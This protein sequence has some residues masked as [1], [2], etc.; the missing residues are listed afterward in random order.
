MKNKSFKILSIPLLF[1]AFGIIL[2]FNSVD[3]YCELK[4]DTLTIHNEFSGKLSQE[5]K[6]SDDDYKNI[7]VKGPMSKADF[8]DLSLIS[9]KCES[10]NIFDVDATTI[11]AGLFRGNLKLKSFTFPKKLK[12][13]GAFS[14]SDCINLEN[15]NLPNTIE[16]I[17]KCAFE[18][19]EKLN[20]TLPS[21]VLCGN[22]A[23][24]GCPNV[25]FSNAQNNNHAATIPPKNVF[26]SFVSYISTLF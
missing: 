20:L 16:K 11:P 4:N 3:A 26:L 18:Y 7:V 19:C 22:Y 9:H 12:S 8:V 21:T 25:S 14:F 17:D 15:A 24:N 1:I 23:F 13:I 5:Y 10:V 2:N 6:K